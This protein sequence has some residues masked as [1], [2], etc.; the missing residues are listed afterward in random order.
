MMRL[1]IAGLAMAT[2][3]AF[4]TAT[5][6]NALLM[7]GYATIPKAHGRDGLE[8][9]PSER[10][11]AED[12]MDIILTAKNAVQSVLAKCETEGRPLACY[13]MEDGLLA[14][15]TLFRQLTQGREKMDMG[16]LR[17]LEHPKCKKAWDQKSYAKII[18]LFDAEGD[19][20]LDFKEWLA[21]D[22]VLQVEEKEKKA[23]INRYEENGCRVFNL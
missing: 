5:P 18:N 20:Y 10:L 7:G 13:L 8:K 15:N 11:A 6:L 3:L 12:A 1:T 2:T 23:V 9:I 19:K 21:L 17:R 16:D 14:K 4:T 22:L